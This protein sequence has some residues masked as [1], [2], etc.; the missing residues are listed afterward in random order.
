[1]A[2]IAFTAFSASTRPTAFSVYDSDTQFQIDADKVVYYV[3]RDLGAAVLESELDLRQIWTNF[4][5]ATLEYSQAINAHHA[6]N[7]LLDMLGQPTG[8]LSGSENIYPMGNS[9]EYSRKMTMQYATEFGGGLQPI[10]TASVQLVDGQQ[11]YDLYSIMSAAYTGS[12]A[13]KNFI[14]REI[15]HYEPFA[16]FR[17]FDTTSV[18]NF[19]GNALNFESYTPETVFYLLPIWE[20]ILRGTQL[21][22]NQRVRRSNYS[23]DYQGFELMLY[24]VPNGRDLPKL[25]FEF[26]VTPNPTEDQRGH[27]SRGVTSNLSNLAFGHIGYSDINS[28]GK[29]WIWKMTLAMSK[30]VLGLIRSKYTELPLGE[31]SISLNGE[32]LLAQAREDQ[33]NLRLELKELLDRMSYKSLMEERQ[34]MQEQAVREWTRVPHFIYISK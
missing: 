2:D 1:M 12:H 27:Q 32:L 15:H 33:A 30:E 7:I 9:V 6:R 20:D 13:G 31:R 34:D 28:I 26:T 14:V 25:Y 24:P 29:T 4:E 18:L 11:R 22:L 16:A 5:A 21:E 3:Q 23:F 10:Y 19:L 17:F 8:S